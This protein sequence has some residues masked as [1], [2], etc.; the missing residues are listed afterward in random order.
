[1]TKNDSTNFVLHAKSDQFYWEGIGQL[2]IKTFSHGKAHYKTNKG[3]FA[4][5]ESR[6]LL[7]NEGSYTISIDETDE[8]ESFCVFFKDGFAAEVLHSLKETN[9]GL[10]SDPFKNTSSIGFFDKTYHKNKTLSYQLET[11]KQ[12]LP[13]LEIDSVGYEEQFYKIMQSI[14]NEH[15]HTY[16]EIESLNAIRNSTRAE[17]YRR[18]SIAHD[19]IRSY[20]DKPLKL[21]E[22]AQ[23][24]LF[25]N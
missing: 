12:I 20:F 16:K 19:Y 10:L 7:L 17:L 21:N 8:V 5:E 2:S 18:I 3:F 23:S 15:F 4:V 14:L 6:Y 1:M 22:V 25:I 24:C 13:S 11:F 9:D